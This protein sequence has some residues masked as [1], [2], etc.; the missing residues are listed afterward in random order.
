[1]LA[2]PYGPTGVHGTAQYAN[3]GWPPPASLATVGSLVPVLP[4]AGRDVE[5]DQIRRTPAR[6]PEDFR[7]TDSAR[8]QRCRATPS[9]AVCLFIRAVG[10]ISAH[11]P[12]W[13][14]CAPRPLR[15]D[16]ARAVPNRRSGQR[17]DASTSESGHAP[18]S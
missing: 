5:V 18:W 15:I 17:G 13:T 8:S 9:G 16:Y 14:I 11:M 2:A 4:A 3:P 12:I 1:V 6:A 10:Q 7:M